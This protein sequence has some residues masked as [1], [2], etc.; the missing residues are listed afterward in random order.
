MT[1]GIMS[2]LAIGAQ[3]V[4]LTVEPQMSYF[5]HVYQRH[6]NFGM[7]S[8]KTAFSTSP[9]L[10]QN[11]GTFTC[12]VGRYGDLLKDVALQI[13]LP[14][15]YSDDTYRFRWIAN[16]PYY[17]LVSYNIN[18]DTY[19]I[20]SRTG[21]WLDIWNELSLPQDKKNIV[22]SLIGNTQE[23]MNPTNLS[24]IVII[25][26]NKIAFS[27]Y[28]T[29]TGPSN[30]SLATRDIYIPLEFWFSKNPALALPLISLQYQQISININ[31]NSVEKLYQIYDHKTDTYL[32]PIT[33]NNIYGTNI[34]IGTFTK[35][36]GGDKN[37]VQVNAYLDLNYLFL[38]TPER[39]FIAQTSTINML[40]EQISR[41][42]LGGSVGINYTTSLVLQNPIKEFIW[43]LRR[44]DAQYYNNW[45]NLTASQQDDESKPILNQAKFMWNGLDRIEFKPGSYYNLLQPY[46][47]H[48]SKPRQGIYAYSHALYPEKSQPSGSFNSSM[49]QTIQLQ[50]NTN[51]FTPSTNTLINTLAATDTSYNLTVYT[52]GYNV[53]KIIG[54][55]GQMA[56]NL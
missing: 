54:G 12:Q 23:Y 44:Q 40:V 27:Y 33:Y 22:N 55:V 47:H 46:M 7:Q 29:S 34:N 11:P 31:F 21:E 1:G 53:F 3:D 25:K 48:T 52:L 6:T 35:Y 51:S 19:T 14:A 26:N 28:P 41:N 49:V 13:T 38:D 18:V 36:G 37:L 43:I 45:A 17:M 24:P 30:P 2:L 42:S 39:T 8:I 56:F 9:T 20:D 32:S 50:I 10:G 4:Y 5:K 15:I 16:M